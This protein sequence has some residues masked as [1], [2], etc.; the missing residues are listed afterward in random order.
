MQATDELEAKGEVLHL[1][2]RSCAFEARGGHL[3]ADWISDLSIG[4]IV[5]LME[6]G[7]CGG[8]HCCTS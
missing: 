3:G 6:L 7:L 2:H 1:A 4:T 5:A 8:L